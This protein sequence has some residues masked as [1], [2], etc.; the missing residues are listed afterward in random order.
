M[1][2]KISAF[3]VSTLGLAL[4]IYSATRSINFISMTLPPDRQI[5]AWFGLAALDGGLI[6]WSLVYLYRSHGWQRP[7]ALIMTFV[8]MIGAFVMFTLDTIYQMGKAGMTKALTQ[9]ELLGAALALSLVILINIAATVAY[10]LADPGRLYE[11][12]EEEA[13]DELDTATLQKI[14][15]DAKNLAARAAPVLAAQWLEG[16][17]E[18]YVTRFSMQQ[19]AIEATAKDV[20]PPARPLFSAL[21]KA[22][23]TDGHGKLVKTDGTQEGSAVKPPFTNKDA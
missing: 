6:T 19:A 15:K 3:L 9:D 22:F 16:A 4:L 23:E 7:I 14:K 8:D 21:Q 1:A 12:A 5:L 18:R 2:K 17:H 10:H 13:F 20:V 11:Q